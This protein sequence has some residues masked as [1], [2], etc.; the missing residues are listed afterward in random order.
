MIGRAAEEQRSP[1]RGV[2]AGWGVRKAG[3]SALVRQGSVERLLHAVVFVRPAEYIAREHPP[4]HHRAITLGMGTMKN[5]GCE[6]EQSID[7][8]EKTY[9]VHGT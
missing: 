8:Y 1:H 5:T 6:K 2:R 7:E 3:H 9:Q 4:K